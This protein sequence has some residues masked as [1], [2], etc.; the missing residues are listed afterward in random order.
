VVELREQLAGEGIVV[1]SADVG[2]VEL[3][4]DG[5]PV[6]EANL[7]GDSDTGAN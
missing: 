5:D 6:V 2:A 1:P 3:L 4:G 7:Q